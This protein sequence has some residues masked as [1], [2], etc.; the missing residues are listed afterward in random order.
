MSGGV[1]TNIKPNI[2]DKMQQKNRWCKLMLLMLLLQPRS[3]LRNTDMDEYTDN[4]RS[5]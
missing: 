3:S 5:V 1:C 2:P 4:S